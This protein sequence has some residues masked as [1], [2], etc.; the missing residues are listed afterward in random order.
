[1]VH[2]V[3]AGVSSWHRHPDSLHHCRP[4][5]LHRFHYNGYYCHRHA[6]P[7]LPLFVSARAARFQPGY[8]VRPRG[9]AESALLVAA[10]LRDRVSRLPAARLA[11]SAELARRPLGAP[12]PG[13]GY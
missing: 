10:F 12:H 5:W 3:V 9:L 7:A 6:V 2:C 1:M 13:W 4:H 8:G 11:D